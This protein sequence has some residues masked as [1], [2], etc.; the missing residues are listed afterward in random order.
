MNLN[1]GIKIFFIDLDGTLLDVKKNGLHSISEAN[2]VAMREAKNKG[3]K[4]VISTGRSGN[5]AKKYLDLIEYDYAVTGNGSII[6][7]KDRIIKSIKMSIKQSLSILEF[8]RRNKLVLKVDDSRI[9][10][11][12]FNKIASYV[13]KKMNFIPVKNF[14]YELHKKPHK[15]VLWG[16]S[17]RKMAKY[18]LL[19]KKMIPGLSIVSSGN[20]WTLEL[21]NENATK[22]SGNLYVASKYGITNKKEMVHIGDSMND[23]TT[24]SYMRLIAMKNSDKNLKKLT[25]YHG[26]SYL[27]SGVA[28]ILNGQYKKNIQKIH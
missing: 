11:G 7:K 27:N 1:E 5:Q 15:I 26:P 20:G 17:K 3:I 19:L 18:S 23:S 25:N 24:A 4:I 12:A 8:A 2:M 14:N 10:H 28:K 22:G 9:G 6:L 21:S 13:T 16:K